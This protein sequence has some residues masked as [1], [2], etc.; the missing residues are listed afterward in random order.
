MNKVYNSTE[1]K[2]ILEGL[3]Y[4]LI[5]SG[6]WWRAKPLYRES[7]NVNSL[8]I[9]KRTGF[10]TDFGA[11]N[12]R[13]SLEDLIKM[14]TGDKEVV[15]NIES[16]QEE[17][18]L[19]T[20]IYFSNEILDTFVPDYD[21][22]RSKKISF[23]TMS[24]FSAGFCQSW[25]LR[26]RIVFPVYDRKMRI[27]GFN[28]RWYKQEPPNKTVPKW[29]KLGRSNNWLYPW[30][31]AINPIKEKKEIIIVESIGD[32][33]SL[34]EINVWNTLVITGAKISPKQISYIV[35]CDPKKIIIALNNDINKDNDCAGN[36]GAEEIRNKLT[37]IFSANRIEIRLPQIEN[38]LSD[39]LTK[40]GRE[41][42][43]QW[44]ESK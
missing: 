33:L 5:N 29:K 24:R 25:K 22:F 16:Y 23:E 30:H 7:N 3:G 10:F 28:G 18:K 32:C 17:E 39:I 4:R 41:K 15:L 38:D 13:G 11:N 37:K 36:R 9:H 6:D 27:I 19:D 21:F 2:S 35:E 43:L 40:H 8:S 1:L 44:Y 12:L 20:N 31:L 42:L 34:A 14:T 26:N